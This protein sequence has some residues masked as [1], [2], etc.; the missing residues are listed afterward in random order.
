MPHS[1]R[2][3]DGAHAILDAA[4]P[5]IIPGVDPLAFRRT[6]GLHDVILPLRLN[7]GECGSV[8]DAAGREVF[9]V[10]ASGESDDKQVTAIATWLALAINAAAGIR[11]VEG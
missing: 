3:G 9:V 8:Q 6:L 4:A 5:A 7:P 11:L 2:E 1:E 10:D